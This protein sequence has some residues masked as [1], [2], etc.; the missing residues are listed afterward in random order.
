MLTPEITKI[1]NFHFAHQI[2][3]M[4][5]DYNGFNQV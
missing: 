1:E 4:A 2:Q 5:T 3:N